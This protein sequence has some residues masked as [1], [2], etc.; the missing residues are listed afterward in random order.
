MF[1]IDNHFVVLHGIIIEYEESTKTDRHFFPPWHLFASLFVLSRIYIHIYMTDGL[2]GFE[3][4]YS[5]FST[6]DNNKN[7]LYFFIRNEII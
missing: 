3:S 6:V 4:H 1:I 7:S 5:F 2:V